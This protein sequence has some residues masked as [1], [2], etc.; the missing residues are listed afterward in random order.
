MT[1]HEYG[2]ALATALVGLWWLGRRLCAAC[3]AANAT[4]WGH[5]WLNRLDGL[6]RLFCRHYHRLNH[7]PITLPQ[8]GGALL[9]SNHV[10][11]LDPLLMIA[12][13][14]RPLRFII[15][16]EEYERFGLN[17]LFRALGC[18]PVARE[19]RAELA[20]RAALRALEA[21][22]VVALFPHGRIHLDGDPPRALKGG[23][24][25]LA[26]LSGCPIY[27]VRITG[28]SGVGRVLGAVVRRSRARLIGFSALT[29]T[30]HTAE[31]CLEELAQVLNGPT[32]DMST[33]P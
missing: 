27:P 11:G 3:E 7:D 24:A 21:G 29:C 12:A 20:L 9:V 14:Q 22:E 15:A 13:A 18:I 8:R 28:I 23:V 25:R 16:Q 4:D 19:Q 5:V 6:N 2:A 30:G 33:D 31:G 17:W 26:A 10:S 32:H 1:I